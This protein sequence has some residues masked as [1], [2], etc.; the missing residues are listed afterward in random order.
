MNS[1]GIPLACGFCALL[2][3]W[4]S[5]RAIIQSAISLMVSIQ[6][7]AVIFCIYLIFTLEMNTHIR[8]LVR[9]ALKLE[10]NI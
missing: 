6:R 2:M 8:I 1:F 4:V 9:D 5:T 10:K 7:M 3:N